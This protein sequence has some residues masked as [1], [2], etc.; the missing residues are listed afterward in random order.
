[1]SGYWH[2][3]VAAKDDFGDVIVDEFIDGR[4]AL[5]RQW[6]IFTPKS[7]KLHGIGR[8]GTGL[9]QL[10]RYQDGKWAKVGS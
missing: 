5:T 2:G 8:L 4:T 9:G 1:M 3:P 10:Y 6:A 7:W